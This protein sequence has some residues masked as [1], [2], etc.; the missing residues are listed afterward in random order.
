MTQTEKPPT[1]EKVRGMNASLANNN[2]MPSPGPLKERDP[3]RLHI[4]RRQIAFAVVLA[5]AA[6]IAALYTVNAVRAGQ[7]A[8][9]AVVTTSRVYDLN[10]ANPGEVTALLV[11]VGQP[12]TAGQVV[13]RQDA[14]TV[15]SQV[16]AD[17]AVVTADQHAL[18]QAEAPEVTAAQRQED[19]LQV[20]QAQT[21][22]S[23]AQADLSAAES[24]G[25]A[26]VAGAEAAA[27]A[28]RQL[29]TADQVR[30]QQ[31]CPNG[32]VP[33]AANLTGAQLQTA[34]AGY[35]QCQSLNATS[36]RD[37]VNLAQAES[38]VPIAQTQG[39]QAINQAQATVN[40]AQA[41]LN[42]AQYQVTL[43]GSPTD[44][45]AVAQAQA[46][47]ATAQGQLAQARLALQQVTLVAPGSG[48]VAEVYGAVGE[49]LGPDG[50]HQ[51]AAPEAVQTNQ[52]SGID[53]FPEQTAP[54]NGGSASGSVEPLLEVIGGDQQV[55]A[56]V[57]ESNVS[58]FPVG[59]RASVSIAALATTT[60]ASVTDVVLNATRSSGSVSY[61]VVLTLGRALPGLL[62]G[63]TAAVRS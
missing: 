18:V 32:L 60:T 31:A 34:E 61:D 11:K 35:T 13:A 23:N 36:N 8:Y 30:Y 39:Q 27:T 56:Q 6:A 57:P 62:P 59:H 21:A 58:R 12:V 16:A 5:V 24:A 2:G 54:S 48:T 17:Q 55:M 20:Q 33:P 41:A 37:Q 29:V 49:Y 40:S 10:F 4:T 19:A 38:Q 53:L 44:P 45:T 26:S 43:Q 25:R 7:Q 9:A 42:T 22:L 3:A 50:V 1:K 15:Q 28:D 14:S 52:H 47:L 51:Y 63:M 46:N